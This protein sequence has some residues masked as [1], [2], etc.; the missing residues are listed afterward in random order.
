MNYQVINNPPATIFRAYDIRGIA[1]TELTANTVYTLGLAI[2]TQLNPTQQ[3]PVQIVVARDGRLSGPE[4]I[5]ALIAGLLATGCDVIDLGLLPT[6][7]L[8]FATHHF[9]IPNG[10]VIT[11]S[12]NPGNYNGLKMMLHGHTL[13]A[14]EIQQLYQEVC[15]GDF[16]SGQG[17][18]TQRDVADAYIDYITADIKLSRKLKVVID[19]G[20]GVSGLFAPRLFKAL[21]CEVHELFC[22]VDGHFP[23]H[24]PD[25]GEPE[26]LQDLIKK[27][28][29]VNADIGLAFDGD[30]DRLGVVT[31]TGEIIYP[32]RQLIMFARDVLARN[33]GGEIIFDVKCSRHVAEQVKKFGGKAT[34]WQTG[35]SLIKAKLKAS[36]ALLAGEMSGHIFFQER[37]FGFDDGLYAGA[38]MLEIVANQSLSATELFAHV[39]QGIVTPEIG[40]SMPDA[41]KFEFMQ[42][43]V[44]QAEFP[45]AQKITIDGLRVEYP[46]GWGLVRCS[47]TSPKL[48]LRFEAD[49]AAA[50]EKIKDIFKQQLRH[51][52]D[53]LDL[54][55]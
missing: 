32:D 19:C 8:Y 1:A 48:A 27:V 17:T 54:N 53:S 49:N 36:G 25:P 2:G 38:R 18:L 23:N 42:R 29:A 4:L 51:L 3:K 55:F 6:P 40:V 43:L 12:H 21:G 45:G 16:I 33:P 22:E 9:K 44:K 30:A 35:H 26:N 52:D 41:K 28:K 14:D 39:P 31:N 34:M 24:H 47:N 50:L 20:N 5:Q 10:I 13:T 37:W 7:M 15:A 11:G 46:E